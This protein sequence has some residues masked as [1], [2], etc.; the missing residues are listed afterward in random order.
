MMS[1]FDRLAQ[2]TC[3]K[4]REDGGLNLAIRTI[5]EF[6]ERTFRCPQTT[7][8]TSHIY[9]DEIVEFIEEKLPQYYSYVTRVKTYKDRKGIPQAEIQIDGAIGVSE[10][11]NR[12]NPWSLHIL[13]RTESPGQLSS[14]QA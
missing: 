4:R 3:T 11:K 14:R 8:K 1:L 6:A 9:C 5:R 2:R 7:P 12:Y 13:V 10:R